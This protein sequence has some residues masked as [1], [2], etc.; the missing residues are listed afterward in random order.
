[1]RPQ[2]HHLHFLCLSS[3]VS[4]V[5]DLYHQ[6]THPTVILAYSE[7][8]VTTPSRCITELRP[9]LQESGTRL[10]IQI[11]L[12][13]QVNPDSHWSPENIQNTGFPREFW[14]GTVQCIWHHKNKIW[15]VHIKSTYIGGGREWH[16]IVQHLS[17]VGLH[18]LISAVFKSHDSLAS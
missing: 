5:A 4:R 7:I 10:F 12:Y 11:C 2:E 14:E 6:N 8:T 3:P 1:M 13:L 17:F 9:F 15:M 16:S 18:G